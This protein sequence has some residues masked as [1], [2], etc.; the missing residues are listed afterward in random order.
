MPTRLCRGLCRKQKSKRVEQ[1]R[2]LRARLRVGLSGSF[3]LTL[4]LRTLSPRFVGYASSPHFVPTLCRK[5]KTGRLCGV[6][7]QAFAKP[8]AAWTYRPRNTGRMPVPVRRQ[9]GCKIFGGTGGASDRGRRSVAGGLLGL[10]GGLPFLHGHCRLL[11]VLFL[12]DQALHGCA[13]SRAYFSKRA[14]LCKR[15]SCGKW[16]KW[17]EPLGLILTHP[18]RL[19]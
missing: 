3:A 16:P 12:D 4:C 14:I 7:D 13:L 17:P 19:S 18:P 2:R 15:K 1:A 8:L 11:A 6:P 5:R 10:L 9:G